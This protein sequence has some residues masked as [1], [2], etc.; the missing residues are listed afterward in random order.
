MKILMSRNPTTITIDTMAYDAMI[1]ME[2]ESTTSGKKRVKELP[3]LDHEGSLS[4]LV[5]LHDLVKFGL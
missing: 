3:V 4:G 2:S 5:T 1:L